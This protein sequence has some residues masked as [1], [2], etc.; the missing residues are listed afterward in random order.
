MSCSMFS[1]ILDLLPH[2]YRI[3]LVGLG[4]PLLHPDVID[5][6]RIAASAGRRIALVTNAQR[7]DKSMSERLIKAGLDSI[8][9]SIDSPDQELAG[10]LRSG[11]NLKKIIHNIK[12]FTSL[13]DKTRPI[14]K[15]VF[16]AVSSKSLPYLEQLI[17]LVAGLGVHILMLSDLNFKENLKD[18]LWK[19]IDDV[20]AAQIK[21]AI[22]HSFSKGLPVLSVRGLEEFGLRQRYMEFLPIPPSKLYKRSQVHSFCLSPWQTIPVNVKGDV[23]ICDCQPEKHTGNLFSDPFSSIWNGRLMKA[24]RRQMTGP[25]PPEPCRICPRF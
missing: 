7:L 4:E 22:G 24:Y 11:T 8:A 13:A 9:F 20:K 14:S 18:S 3:T 19:N 5:I 1:S 21:H 17:D 16:S 25:T 12:T 15:A 23:T 2:A 6:V 10:W